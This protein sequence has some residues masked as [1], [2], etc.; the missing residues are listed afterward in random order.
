MW[1]KWK[2]VKKGCYFLPEEL[3]NLVLNTRVTQVP[4]AF[5]MLIDT[6]SQLSPSGV[7]YAVVKTYTRW[8][9]LFALFSFWGFLFFLF[10]FFSLA[11]SDFFSLLLGLVFS[12]PLVLPCTLGTCPPFL[13]LLPFL[14][15]FR[16]L[17]FTFDTSPLNLSIISIITGWTACNTGRKWIWSI[18]RNGVCQP[19][20]QVYISGFCV[21]VFRLT[22]F[23][24]LTLDLTVFPCTDV[25]HWD[26]YWLLAKMDHSSNG[27]AATWGVCLK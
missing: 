7:H 8:S 19:I 6:T 27:L 3:K 21:D 11:L 24:L 10:A 2:L 14:R 9:H 25:D 16:F 20:V 18:W 5:W 4:Q 22:A 12:L 26:S 23:P 1:S 15:I 13:P 17:S